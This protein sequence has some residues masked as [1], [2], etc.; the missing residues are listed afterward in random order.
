MVVNSQKHAAR[1]RFGARL[2]AVEVTPGHVRRVA[3]ALEYYDPMWELLQFGVCVAYAALACVEILPGIPLPKWLIL[4]NGA[5]WVV[6]GVGYIWRLALAR[7]PRR[8]WRRPLCLLDLVVLASF[9]VLLVTGSGV[10]GLACL[11][12]AI[13]QAL[14]LGWARRSA[15]RWLVPVAFVVVITL[16][17]GF[18]W[19][20]E[21]NHADSGIQS[22]WD[23]L[24]WAIAAMLQ[25]DYGDTYPHTM[26][27]Q[28]PAVILMVL[29]IALFGWV[30]AALASWFVEASEEDDEDTVEVDKLELL[31]ALRETGRL[32]DEEF[33]A[34]KAALIGVTK[35]GRLIA[36]H[37][38]GALTDEELILLKAMI[39]R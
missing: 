29:G 9:P 37:E 16:V 8:Y 34:R 17:A 14:N 18:V 25:V 6:L 26:G 19:R 4:L 31:A 28:V 11:G 10:L 24:W 12:R 32:S 5:L 2:R 23:A 15:L 3:W 35:V 1:W 22:I 38:R 30:T 7:D 20:A 39:T 13:P 21:I 33:A 27:G 36:L